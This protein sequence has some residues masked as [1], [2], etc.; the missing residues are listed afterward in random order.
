M[1]DC[2][3][4]RI[5]R[6]LSPLLLLLQV[7]CDACKPWPPPPPTK[8]AYLAAFPG[9]L[10][11]QVGA[12]LADVVVHLVGQVYDQ[13]G[14]VLAGEPLQFSLASTDETGVKL[15]SASTAGDTARFTVLSGTGADRTI[16]LTLA[17]AASALSLDIPV[18]L[19]YSVG[20]PN[21]VAVSPPIEPWPTVGMASGQEGMVWKKHVARAFVGRVGLGTFEAGGGNVPPLGDE[22]SGTVLSSTN[23]LW[24]QVSPWTGGPFD[25]VVPASADSRPVPVPLAPFFAGA[26]PS[27]QAMLQFLVDL[28]GGADIIEHTPVGV[29]VHVQGVAALAAPIKW[30]R[31]CAALGVTLSSLPASQRPDVS[32]LAVYMVERSGEVGGD[33]PYHC[34]PGSLGGAGT[35]L[36]DANAVFLPEGPISS[37]S[38]AH[39]IGHAF[40]LTHVTMWSGFFDN[41]LMVETFPASAALRDHLSV[42]QA[43]RAAIDRRSW[44]ALAGASA[45]ARVDCAAEHAK[46]PL[47]NHDVSART[48]P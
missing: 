41:D 40:S 12:A 15:E 48:P 31:D 19:H 46:C 10:D 36:E 11:I 18:H 42:G 22:P 43:F 37:A 13:Y 33:L 30:S 4:R 44:I 39:E 2:G 23:A 9:E 47:L 21:G 1:R 16:H 7:G 45:S 17:H 6:V 26:T 14:S 5:T 29:V 28:Q 32:R 38:V 3:S 20:A 27:E 34:P 24:R 8:V 35:P 25:V